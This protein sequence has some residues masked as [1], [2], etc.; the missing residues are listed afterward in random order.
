MKI[1]HIQADTSQLL[2][3]LPEA[4]PE[5]GYLWLDCTREVD[6]QWPQLV[7]R[8]EGATIHERHVHDSLN[9]AHVCFHDFTNE[10]DMLIFRSTNGDLEGNVIGPPVAFFL[11]QRCLVSVQPGDNPAIAST[12]ERLNTH[13]QRS[14]GSAYGLLHAILNNMVDQMLTLKNPL[15]SRLEQHS[16]GLLEA[17]AGSESWQLLLQHRRILRQLEVLTEE[18]ESAVMSMRESE[19]QG[20]DEHLRV[21]YTDL[22]EHIRRMSRLSQQQ[23]QELDSVL[24]LHFSAVAFRTNAIIRT[25]TLLSAVFLPL[26]LI[27]GI[28]GMN[29]HNMPAL[30]SEHG[31]LLALGAMGIIAATILILFRVKRW[32]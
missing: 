19:H 27:A 23:Q 30:G 8:L 24:Q 29:F 6:A 22:L 10:Y 7:Q 28:Y 11:T 4:L 21:R 25:L 3:A 32:W 12:L 17:N 31:Y 1:H 2:E 15:T 5:S 18:Q 13:V 9:I 16:E 14:P 20:S 26:S